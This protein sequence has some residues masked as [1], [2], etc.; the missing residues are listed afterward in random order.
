MLSDIRAATSDVT[1]A[2][3]LALNPER[4][5]EMVQECKR[6]FAPLI[7]G[8]TQTQTATEASALKTLVDSDTG[9]ACRQAPRWETGWEARPF[10]RVS[11]RTS[12]RVSFL[13]SLLQRQRR[14]ERIARMSPE[15]RAM[16]EEIRKLREEI[17]PINF[18][19]VEALREIRA[20]E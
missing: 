4:L 7:V 17:G 2:R 3:Q 5:A 14:D 12:T 16:Y 15:R 18:N 10:V 20:D 1:E 13:R 8:A 9:E 6:R 11:T 19:V